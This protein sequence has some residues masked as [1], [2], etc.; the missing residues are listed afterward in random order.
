MVEI[1]GC[2]NQ[3]FTSDFDAEA[4]H[5]VKIKSGVI[6][7]KKVSDFTANKCLILPSKY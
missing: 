1:R 5:K 3:A 2:T 7:K 4:D 6:P